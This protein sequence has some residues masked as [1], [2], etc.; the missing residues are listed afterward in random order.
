MSQYQNYQSQPTVAGAMELPAHPYHQQQQ[1]QQQQEVKTQPATIM[2]LPGDYYHPEPQRT[3]PRIPHSPS[4]YGNN[5]GGVSPNTESQRWSEYSAG[6]RPDSYAS[7]TD[8][9]Y[10]SQA[11]YRQ[12]SMNQRHASNDLATHKET[13]E[14]HRRSS[15]GPYTYQ[16]HP[17]VSPLMG[18]DPA[19]LDADRAAALKQLEAMNLN[20]NPQ[21]GDANLRN[22]PAVTGAYNNE[23]AALPSQQVA[24]QKYDGHN[25]VPLPLMPRV[26][27]QGGGKPR[28]VLP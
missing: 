25:Q 8:S 4:D 14:E 9:G 16:P 1:P 17:A 15:S 12:S 13:H 26:P 6:S 24:A 19:Q 22:H 27:N 20:S 11:P 3:S 10:G 7:N 5:A 18:R 23:L 2:E 21:Y 28:V